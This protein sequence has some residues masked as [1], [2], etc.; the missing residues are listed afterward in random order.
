MA[1]NEGLVDLA[2]ADGCDGH[3]GEDGSNSHRFA[4]LQHFRER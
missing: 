1:R 4:T 2:P 3:I